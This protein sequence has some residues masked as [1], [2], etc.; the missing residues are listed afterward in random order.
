MNYGAISTPTDFALALASILGGAARLVAARYRDLGPLTLPLW[1]R[2]QRAAGRFTRLMA[3]LAAGSLLTPRP[4]PSR[5]RPAKPDPATPRP[6]AIPRGRLWLIGTL[7]Y[8][9]AGVRAQLEA[10][11]NGPV[12]AA[13]LAAAPTA[14][15]TLR[16]I[17]R[18][19]GLPLPPALQLPPRP[20][21]PARPKPPAPPRPD[22]APSPSPFRRPALSVFGIPPTIIVPFPRGFKNSA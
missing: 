10:L 22:L 20:P 15:R 4:R 9:A 1:T 2:F 3:R 12:I 19:L 18:L 8:Q 16:P 5:P 13:M 11:L 7:G 21:R 6:P 14:G 17:C